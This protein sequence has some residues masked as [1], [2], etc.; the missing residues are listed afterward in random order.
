[1]S[2]RLARE[3]AF[4]TIFQW[5]LGKNDTEPTLT[6]LVADSELNSIY[7]DFARELVIGTIN[8]H[9]EIDN[10]ISPYLQN[11]ELDRLAVADRSVLRLEIGRASCRGRV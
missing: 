11:W 1:M 4:K 5:D 8:K 10:A 2:R 7:A 6:E 3:I 9:D